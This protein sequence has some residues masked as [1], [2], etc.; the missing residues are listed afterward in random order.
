MSSQTAHPPRARTKLWH[1]I[2]KA[3]RHG[4]FVLQHCGECGTVQYPPREVCGHCLSTTLDWRETDGSG[5]VQSHVTLH[6]SLDPWFRDRLPVTIV[7]VKLDAGP[8]LY[9]FADKILKRDAAVTVRAVI[10]ES[11]EAVLHAAEKSDGET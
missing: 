3:A 7:L 4:Q 9:A 6:T 5:R 11:G 8:V 1:D 2:T 10:D